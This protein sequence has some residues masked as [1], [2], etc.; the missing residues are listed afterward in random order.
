MRVIKTTA[1]LFIAFALCF[2]TLLA[3]DPG[4]EA[5]SNYITASQV[6]YPLHQYAGKGFWVKGMVKSSYRLIYVRCGVKTASGKWVNGVNVIVNPKSFSYDLNAV[7]SRIVF[8]RLKAGT[9][10][11]CVEARNTAGLSKTLMSRSFTVSKIYGKKTSKPSS[12]LVKGTPVT[13]SGKVKSHFKISSIR[14]GITSKSGKWKKGFFVQKIP[15]SR[16]YNIAKADPHIKF[17]KLGTGTYRYKVWA[18]D[19]YGKKKTVVSKKFKV[20]RKSSNINSSINAANGNIQSKGFRLSYKSSLISAIGRQ[21]VSGPCGQYAMAYCRAV[22]DGRFPLKSKY[23]SYYKQLYHEYGYGS[24]YAYW[25]K[26]DGSPVWY[27]SNK[28]CYKAALK[29]IAY[30]RPCIINLHNNSTGNNHFVAVIGYRA[31]TNYS[32]VS[33]NSFIA[34]DPG[35]GKLVYLKDMNYSNSDNPEAVFF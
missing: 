17:G 12:S 22:L 5:K 11:Y 21:P 34:L 10:V 32:N 13:I 15:K 2:S 23:K 6:T 26:A 33:L 1:V 27:S 18:S 29:K 4:A 28:S 25:Y 8:G 31:G 7:D 3:S 30:G 20:V 9:Y 24:H 19:I 14:V 16:S 35:Y